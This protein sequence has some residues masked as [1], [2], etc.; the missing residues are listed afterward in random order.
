MTMQ[1][2]DDRSLTDSLVPL[3]PTHLPEEN[4]GWD[5]DDECVVSFIECDWIKSIQ[6]VSEISTT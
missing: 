2:M 5:D 1:S 3:F 6:I 4:H